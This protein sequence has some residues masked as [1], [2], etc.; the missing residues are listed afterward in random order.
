MLEQDGAF[1]RKILDID[2]DIYAE[3]EAELGWLNGAVH[4]EAAK[5]FELDKLIVDIVKQLRG[6]VLEARAEVAHLKAIGLGADVVRRRQPGEQRLGS[7]AVVAVESERDERSTSSSTPVPPAIRRN[8]SSKCGPPSPKSARPRLQ[9]RLHDDAELPSRPTDADAP[10]CDGEVT[11]DLD[12]Q[13]DAQS[14]GHFGRDSTRSRGRRAARRNVPLWGVGANDRRFESRRR[15][16][17]PRSGPADSR[18]ES[19]RKYSSSRNSTGTTASA[20][21]SARDR[22]FSTSFSAFANTCEL[23]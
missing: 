2:Y 9:A 18:T 5:P 23:S 6:C 22:Y 8:W 17:A 10:L 15:P 11:I 4:V 21:A 19:T 12:R 1:G 16:A 20:T 7:G 3:G 14:E 13:P